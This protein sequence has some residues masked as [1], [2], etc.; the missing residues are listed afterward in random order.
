[1]ELPCG[2]VVAAAVSHR[3]VLR[4]AQA[5][6]IEASS[7]SS[8]HSLKPW[9]PPVESTAESRR[10]LH[11]LRV[12]LGFVAAGAVGSRVARTARSRRA[13]SGRRLRYTAAFSAVNAALGLRRPG[14]TESRSSSSV[15]VAAQK[16]LP[17]PTVETDEFDWIRKGKRLEV[18]SPSN[19]W[20]EATVVKRKKDGKVLLHYD[21]YD[22]QFDELLSVKDGRLRKAGELRAINIANKKSGFS[23]ARKVGCCPGCGAKFQCANPKGLGY[24][25]ET[26][27]QVEDPNKKKQVLRPEEEVALFLKEEGAAEL[28]NE[29]QMNRA[30]QMSY[31][32]IANILLDIRAE[33]D[34]D[35]ERTGETLRY[36]DNFNVIE[37]YRAPD[38]RT[39]FKLA[40]GR[41]W[42]FDWAEINNVKTFLVEPQD[43]GLKLIKE[44][45]NSYQKVCMRCW[46]L[47]QYN[48]V[49]DI[50]R[51]GWGGEV[52]D[53]LTEEKFEDML[54]KTLDPV[55]EAT[56]LAVVDVFD[57]GPSA[58]MLAFLA[59]QLQ[60]KKKVQVKV[61]ANK[62][63][64]LPKDVN[65]ARL[66]GWISREAQEAGLTRVKLVDVF[67][68]SCHNG[69]GVSSVS[70]LL[71]KIEAKDMFYIVGAANAGKSSLLNRLALR[72]RKG[73]GRVAANAQDGFMVSLLPGTTLGTLS[74]KYDQGKRQ[75]VDT[76]GLLVDGSLQPRLSMEE[77]RAVVPQ[78]GGTLRVTFHMLGTNEHK[79]DHKPTCVYFGG[80]ARIDMLEGRPYRF[81]C[82]AAEHVKLHQCKLEKAEES[83]SKLVGNPL[84]PPFSK[85]RYQA[86]QP[87]ETHRFELQGCGWD[88]ACADIVFHGL[89][90]VSI[91]GCGPCVI[92]AHAPKGVAVTVREPLMPHEAK[93]TGVKYYGAPGWYKVG[94]QK[95][96]AHGLGKIRTKVIGKKF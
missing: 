66:R 4:D 21:G 26:H 85:S 35:S 32:V 43:D 45:K 16:G 39:Y 73:V 31:M 37:T 47:W 55:M 75:I 77:L 14:S 7:V 36:G 89:G 9:Q 46:G 30:K 59:K 76:P 2:P 79:E 51:P 86:L 58:R 93:W 94:T 87:W 42:V 3:A 68:I 78:K 96:T 54:T 29:V 12:C 52:G 41:G 95:T 74:V 20:R 64:C 57:F 25:P 88:E 19:R 84:T 80:L 44:K 50:L 67:P 70:K 24:I 15:A 34:M 18:L 82:F 27:L 13:D 40:D 11:Q 62:V 56:I 48:D 90:W 1:M 83:F 69:A 49:D 72:K 38:A 22:H 91:T 61:V 28:E 6:P 23:V 92:E 63:D 71:E 17:Q 5:F 81:T 8:L 53:E 65:L 60:Y 10:Q 33:P